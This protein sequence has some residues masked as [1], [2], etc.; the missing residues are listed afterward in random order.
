M[1]DRVI[2]FVQKILGFDRYLFLISLFV[3]HKFRWDKAEKDFL[4]IFDQVTDDGIV[5][6]IGA[7]IGVMTA[8]FSQR[9]KNSQIFSFEP[10]PHN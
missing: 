3:Y 2:S 9:L 7:N 1:R 8:L 10:V 5:L 4:K 6:D